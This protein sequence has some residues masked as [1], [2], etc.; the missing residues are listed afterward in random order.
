MRLQGKRAALIGA[1]SVGDGWGNGKAT[2]VLFARQG[3]SVL[4]VDRDKTA[5]EETAHLINQEGGIAESLV[6]DVCDPETGAK[7]TTRMQELWGGTDILDYNVGTSLP[8][9]VLETTDEGW[10]R[11][12]DINLTGAMRLTRAILPSMI[13]QGSGSLLYVSSLAAVYSAP[14]S[15]TSYEVSKMAL[16]RFAKSVA[17]ENAR[18]GIRANAIL[19]GVIDTPHVNAFVDAETPPETLAARRAAMVPLGR[20]GTAWDIANAAL[21]LASDEA[22][23]ITGEALKVDGGLTA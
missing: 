19:P 11:V 14:Y 6:A 13:E 12:M 4:C 21:F 3:A 1:G 20:Q 16:I 9:G 5:A 7:V 18:H 22:G 23:F 17:R 15:Y 2:A 10:D 8:G